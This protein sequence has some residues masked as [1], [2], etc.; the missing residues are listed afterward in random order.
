M[1][2]MDDVADISWGSAELYFVNATLNMVVI[3]PGQII[4][5]AVQ[6]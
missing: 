4:A 1:I 5:M 3:K 2:M 6:I